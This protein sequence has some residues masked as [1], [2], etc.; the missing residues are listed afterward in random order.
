MKQVNPTDYGLF[1]EFIDTFSKDGFTGIDPNHPLMLE[2]DEMMEVNDQFF[3]IA[4]AIQMNILFASKRSIKMIGIEPEELTFYQFME[5]TH[6]DE[7]PRLN[8]GRTQILKMAQELFTA[9]EGIRYL[10]T[11]FRMRHPSGIYSN[12][13]I[14][15]YLVYTIIPRKTVLFLK[16][17]TGI[18][19]WKKK[20]YGFHY[21]IGKD[22]SYFRYPDRELLDMGMHIS[23]RE[24]EILKLVAQGLSSEQIAEDLFLSVNTV[25][26]HRCNMLKKTGKESIADLIYSYK[27]NGLM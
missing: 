16:I 22:L 12:I 18:D 3:Y 17:H 15:C 23:E 8:L 4:D 20:E 14:Q 2:L 24:Y 13:L 19:W 5:L 6:P 10:S 26:T 7:F 11:D 25:H 21:Y 9:E 1:F 27:E